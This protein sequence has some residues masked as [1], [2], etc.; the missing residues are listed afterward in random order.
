[1]PPTTPI[2]PPS[3]DSH[4]NDSA[5]VA[6]LWTVLRKHYMAMRRRLFSR[7]EPSGKAIIVDI[8]FEELRAVLGEQFFAPNWETSYYFRGE[9][10]NLARVEYAERHGFEWWQT[11]VRGWPN[12]DGSTRL[13]A[14]YE[15]EPTEHPREHVAGKYLNSTKGTELTAEA[16]AAHSVPHHIEHN[17]PPGG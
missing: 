7:P 8:G 4:S 5:T 1:M 16:L 3:P 15:L 11:H 12:S 9:V 14:H 2:P 6:S 10:L 13:R 17:L